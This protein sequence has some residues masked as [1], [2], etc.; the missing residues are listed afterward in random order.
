MNII[1]IGFKNVGKTTVG[2]HIA[3]K[4]DRPFFDTDRLIEKYVYDTEKIF[5]TVGDIYQQ[6]G[7]IYFRFL[8]NKIITQLNPSLAS[9]IA[10]GGGSIINLENATYLQKKGKI[11]YLHASFETLL[12]RFQ[13]SNS[14]FLDLG[15]EKFEEKLYIL[16]KE[17]INHY[18]HITDIEV[19]TDNKS[20]IEISNE[21]LFE[22]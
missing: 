7:S 4:T 8:E 12:N 10:T 11:I 16:Y 6:K 20:I 3:K 17:R 21:I 14:I 5:L 2:E 13:S 19:C 15:R 1:L 18:K 22:I 9:V